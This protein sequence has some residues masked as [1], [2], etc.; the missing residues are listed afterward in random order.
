MKTKLFFSTI[1][2]CIASSCQ[3]QHTFNNGDKWIPQNFNPS[4]GS[5]L[6]MK[7]EEGDKKEGKRN[8]QMEEYLKE[9]YTYQFA[10]ATKD[11]IE[12]SKGAYADVKKFPFALMV[13]HFYESHPP[14]GLYSVYDFY[15][16][17]RATN[18]EFPLTK[19]TTSNPVL[20]FKPVINTI[21]ER[22][23]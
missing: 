20:L 17:D 14:Y 11:E 18:T 2:F 6:V 3:A 7:L 22:F 23:K 9:K 21:L 13:K 16:V 10:F 1:L 4:T 15:F 12:N 5:L 8:E 19:K